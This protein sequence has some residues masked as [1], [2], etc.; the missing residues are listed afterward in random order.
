MWITHVIFSI[1]LPLG[2]TPDVMSIINNLN[3]IQ[4][5]KTILGEVEMNISPML[6]KTQVARTAIESIEETIITILCED[7]FIRKNIKTKH[8]DVLTEAIKKVAGKEMEIV[9]KVGNTKEKGNEVDKAPVDNL[10]PLFQ[11]KDPNIVIKEK[12]KKSNLSPKFTFENFIMG[13]N[14]NLAYAIATAVAD[15]PGELYNPVFLYSSVGLGKTHLMQAI[16]NKILKDR[17]GTNVIYTTGETFMNELIEAIKGD[18]G[19]QTTNEFRN[20]FR[21]TDVLLV[22]DVQFI[23]GKEATQEEFFH[24]FNALYMSQKQIVITSDRPPK[25]FNGIEDRITSRFSSGIIVDIQAPDY[26]MR[27]AILRTKRDHNGDEI[28]ND[29][30]DFIAQNIDSNIREL[31]GAYMQVATFAKAAGIKADINLAARALGQSIR[32]KPQKNINANEILKAVCAY[33]SV[34]A[35]DIKGKK[36]TK[37]IVIPRQVAMYLIKDL[38]NSPF[39]TIG[40][41]LGG[42]DHTTIMHGVEKVESEISLMGKMKQDVTNVKQMIIEE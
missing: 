31:E 15:K 19:K 16:G 10:G 21:K 1:R 5:W 22:D 11:Q 25:D 20:K 37:D 38:T 3:K 8:F 28:Q 17:P 35:A 13:A 32:E 34:K 23:I 26:E 29:V 42:R 27:A 30:I 39:M 40:D 12:Q 36:R 2:L 24:T 18:K 4:F 9:L 41:L 6:F 33:Y 14:N 7:E